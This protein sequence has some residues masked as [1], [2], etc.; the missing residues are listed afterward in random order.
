MELLSTVLW[1]LEDRKTLSAL[2][3]R[4]HNDLASQTLPE[5]WIVIAN[6][7]SLQGEVNI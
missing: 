3:L 1:Y 5:T 7:F 6:A 4:M 2:A